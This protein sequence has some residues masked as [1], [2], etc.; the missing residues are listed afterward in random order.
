MTDNMV[1]DLRRSAV[2][3]TYA[4]GSVVDMRAEKA[5]VSG[6]SAG[7]EE[8]DKKAP[9]TGNLKY[10]KIIER[11]LCKKLGKKYFRLPPVLDKDAKLANG[12][13]DPASLVI[14]RFPE[15]LQCPQCEFLRPASKWSKEPG[16]AYRYCAS[17]SAGRAGGEKIFAI[18]VRFVAACTS[19]HLEEFPWNWWV[20]HKSGCVARDKLKL[21]STG[22]GLAGLMLACP[23]CKQIR[24]L[25]GAFGKRA[26]SG[27]MC[28]GGRPWLRSNDPLCLC[29]GESGTF[30]AM[31]R[32]AS[33][34]YYPVMESALDIPPWTR[35]LERILGDYWDTLL[36]IIDY[37]GRVDYIKK[38]Q[39]LSRVIEREKIA[40]EELARKFDEMSENSKNLR[41]DNLLIDEYM[42]F[43][44]SMEENDQEFEVHRESVPEVLKPYIAKV[45]RVARLRE[46]RVVRGFTRINA[47]FD[48]N[49]GQVAPISNGMM[50]WLPAIEVRGEGIFIQFNLDELEKWEV[51]KQ[52]TDRVAPANASWHADWHNRGT[53]EPIP[54]D[55]SPRLLM[56]H[57]FAHA[58]IRQLTV[59]C[60]YS[61]ASLRERLYVSEGSSSMAG[62]LI[63]TATS[64]SDGTLGGLQRRAGADL[65]ESTV[66][67]ALRSS[68]WCSSDPLCIAGE[69]CSTETHSIASC[70]ACMLLPETSCEHHNRF[71]DRALLT[72]SEGDDSVGFFAALLP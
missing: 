42:V 2:V 32:G 68:Q 41:T 65:L 54:F 46:V 62:L 35:T 33:N 45:M 58:L 49:G 63:Y 52:V 22:P 27:L 56:V 16:K 36:D 21:S 20:S 66:I 70:H 53:N 7:L 44:G 26:L 12:M 43:S 29:S 37:E 6:V 34:L 14:R 23:E 51:R 9:L 48:P 10:Q 72:G 38:S 24:S 69:I 8:W 60:G 1:G 13:P 40:A 31:Q 28:K 15:W 71:L 67:G 39:H 61:T 47:P 55:A 25:D 3:M 50:D 11:R 4:P 18:P 57:A 59:E 30:R 64:D 5:P 17:C 19:G